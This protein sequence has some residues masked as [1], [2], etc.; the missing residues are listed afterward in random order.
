MKQMTLPWSVGTGTE[1]VTLEA[2]EL[3]VWALMN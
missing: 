2:F 1:F 3:F